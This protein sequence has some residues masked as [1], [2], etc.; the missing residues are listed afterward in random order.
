MPE[1]LLALLAL[2]GNCGWFVSGRKYRAEAEREKFDLSK[3]YID[4]FKS[5]IYDPLQEELQK[6]RTAI[7]A[8]GTCEHRDACPVVDKLRDT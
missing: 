2:L 4:E 7:E 3:L 1:L 6:L 5:H 8:V